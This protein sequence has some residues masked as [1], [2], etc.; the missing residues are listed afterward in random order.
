[1][2]YVRL[3]WGS[4]VGHFTYAGQR[5]PADIL[6]TCQQWVTR[7]KFTDAST[8]NLWHRT[9]SAD[10]ALLQAVTG[11]ASLGVHDVRRL[12]TVR[13]SILMWYVG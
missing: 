6:V 2:H 7:Y 12:G 11:A 1:M 8:M 10:H 5:G 4:F 3:R 13:R 9:F